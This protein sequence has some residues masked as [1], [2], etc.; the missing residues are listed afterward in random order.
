MAHISTFGDQYST[1]PD[2]P[3]IVVTKSSSEKVA[4]DYGV[5]TLRFT[6]S[7]CD[8]CVANALRRI[9]ISEV[10]ISLATQSLSLLYY[11]IVGVY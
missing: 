8:L 11:L 7:D 10:Y 9:I 5:P 1:V 4:T 6:L 2:V 3:K